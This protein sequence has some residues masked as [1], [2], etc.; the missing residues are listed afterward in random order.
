ME[1]VLAA[2]ILI[3]L[4]LFAV[5]TLS[6]TMMSTQDMLHVSW[7]ESDLSLQEQ[8]HTALSIVNAQTHAGTQVELSVENTGSIKLTDFKQWDVI[9]QYRDNNPL[10]GNHI[11]WMPYSVTPAADKWTVQGI[12]NDAT[13]LVSESYDRGIFDPGEEAILGLQLN[14]RIEAGS[15]V[16]VVITTPNGVSTSTVFKCNVPPVLTTNLTIHVNSG[17]V[18]TITPDQLEVTDVDDVPADLVYTVSTTPTNGI[19]TPASDFTQ[20]DISHDVLQ[21]ANSSGTSDSFEFTVSDGEDSIGAYT[22]QIQVNMPPT[23]DVNNGMTITHGTAGLIGDLMLMANDPDNSDSEL[24]FSVTTPPEHGNLS[25]STFSQD[26]INNAR[27][28]YNNLSSSAASDSFTFT[29]S[30]GS[31]TIGSFIF[32]ITVN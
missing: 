23:L 28:S 10:S 32:A 15:Y 4:V 14:P 25:M 20:D 7:E 6:N 17:E 9:V 27:I 3:F 21:Y 18:V 1:T 12:Y 31:K 16:Q 5:L 30:D 26:D 19:L 2:L 22:A 8:T 24:I 13:T 11:E 29:V